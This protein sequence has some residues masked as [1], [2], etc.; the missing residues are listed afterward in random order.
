[1]A[2]ALRN[3]DIPAALSFASASSKLVGIAL[4]KGMKTHQLLTAAAMQRVVKEL[5]PILRSYAPDEE[6]W[7]RVVDEI[8]P[9]LENTTL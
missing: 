6:T 8:A 2:L 1:M 4:R 5:I 3:E 7:A 9:H